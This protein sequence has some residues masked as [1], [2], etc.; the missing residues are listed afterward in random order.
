MCPTQSSA[1]SAGLL[2]RT[3]GAY[4]VSGPEVS[5]GAPSQACGKPEWRRPS[6]GNFPWCVPQR[7]PRHRQQ[8]LR[9]RQPLPQRCCRGAAG[10]GAGHAFVSTAQSARHTAAVPHWHT[11]PETGL[12]MSWRTL[13]AAR[14]VEYQKHTHRIVSQRRAGDAPWSLRGDTHAH[15]E[16]C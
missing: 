5:S 14:F 13:R 11:V 6:A 1:L 15:I 16:S 4:S 9:Q 7:P 12:Q 8:R 2:A 10:R 3:G